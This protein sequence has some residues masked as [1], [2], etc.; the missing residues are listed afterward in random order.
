MRSAILY[1]VENV[2]QVA[3]DLV[4]LLGIWFVATLLHFG[5]TLAALGI[6]DAVTGSAW[7]QPA[8]IVVTHALLAPVLLAE[9]LGILEWGLRWQWLWL[10]A[11]SLV[12]VL[13]IHGM[14]VF[15]RRRI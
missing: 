9:F 7:M 14:V 8:A 15:L 13:V 1:R 12:W 4:P 3:G 2:L 5:V 11:N 10:L 6:A